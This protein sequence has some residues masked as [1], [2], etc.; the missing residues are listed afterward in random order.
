MLRPLCCLQTL[1][2]KYVVTHRPIPEE[3]T[4]HQHRCKTLKAG[5]FYKDDRE[6][7]RFVKRTM[8]DDI[9][10]RLASTGYGK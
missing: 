8:A 7:K 9:G 1:G 2:T 5:K 6:M 3:L 4:H 10:H